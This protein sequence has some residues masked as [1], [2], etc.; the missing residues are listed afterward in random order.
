MA[1]DIGAASARTSAVP[2]SKATPEALVEDQAPEQA[3]PKADTLVC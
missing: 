1:E 2:A 3:M